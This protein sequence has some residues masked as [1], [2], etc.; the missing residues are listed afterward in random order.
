MPVKPASFAARS[1]T[2]APGRVRRAVLTA[3]LLVGLAGPALARENL[4]MFGE[5]GAFKDPT[6]PRCYAIAKAI[7]SKLRRDYEPYATIG[8]WPKRGIRNQVH[9]RMSRK[10]AGDPRLILRIGGE[11]F[12][13]TGGGGDAWAVDK[14]MNAAIV[15]KL[16]S[17]SSVTVLA[18]GADGK[19][20]SNTW[21]LN[22][23]AS[24]MDAAAIGCAKAR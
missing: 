21:N 23:V 16:R 18:R 2:F 8:T 6:V 17:A 15:A 24:A 7:P 13:L 20:F 11:R 12:E 3:I 4:G 9:F 10:M 14:R 19:G 5:W 1:T 22:G